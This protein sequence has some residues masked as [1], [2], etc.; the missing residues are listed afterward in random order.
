ML[1]II[2]RDL[3]YVVII[4]IPVQHTSAKGK[5]AAHRK[6]I[7]LQ[8][9]PL[10]D[11]LKKPGNGVAQSEL[12]TQI[13]RSEQIPDIA[14]PLN[15]GNYFSYLVTRT[16]ISG[17]ISS[18]AISRNEQ[19]SGRC[20]FNFFKYLLRMKRSVK[21]NKKDSSIHELTLVMMY[22]VC[23]MRVEY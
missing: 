15:I 18:R 23:S 2:A 20:F 22:C 8:N 13:F 14:R 12:A 10:I 9:D 21:H 6:T 1:K 11:V 7:V 16:F 19:S 3:K 5:K 17:M 4:F